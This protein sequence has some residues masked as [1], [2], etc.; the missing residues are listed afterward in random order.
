MR[1]AYISPSVLPSLSANSVHVCMQC[2]ALAESGVETTLFAGRTIPE[3]SILPLILQECYVSNHPKFALTT[4]F[5]SGRRGDTLRIACLGLHHL[6]HVTRPHIILSR[7][8]YASFAIA[9]L[10]RKTILF[11]IHQ[12]ETGHHGLMQ[13]LIMRCPW[14]STIVISNRMI[15][16]LQDH[17][18]VRPLDALVLHD[19]APEGILPLKRHH[20]RNELQSL[21]P[22]AE[23]GKG[24]VCG[25]FGHLYAGRGIEIIENMADA[26]NGVTFLVFGGNPDEVAARRN[27]NK[28]PNLIFAGHVPH[29]VANRLM[30]AVDVLLMP[31][32]ERVSIGIAGHD[33]ARWMSPMKM[34]EYMASGV[35]IISSDLQSLREILRDG[36]NALLVPPNKL[37]AWLEALD[38][39][40]ADP[41]LGDGIGARAHTQYRLHHTWKVRA[42]RIINAGLRLRARQ[43]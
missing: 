7:N 18:G 15:D 5:S 38:R 36:E 27:A 11:E 37:S 29:P 13:R 41:D 40:I 30:R 26:R 33:T 23:L 35:P 24:P 17:H 25:Y 39:L 31:Y 22:N 9:I 43:L 14:V 6:L 28:R 21:L 2:Q 32:Q 10:L 34:F 16:C 12:L 20:R 19:A 1:L 3:E 42:R 8:L 4:C